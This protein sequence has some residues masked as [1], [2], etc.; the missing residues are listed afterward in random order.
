M[1]QKKKKIELARGSKYIKKI[2]GTGFLMGL[3][4]EFELQRFLNYRISE[5]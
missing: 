5:V 4:E 1:F 3:A 2:E